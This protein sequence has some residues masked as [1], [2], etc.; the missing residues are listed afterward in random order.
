MDTDSRIEQHNR[1][2]LVKKV[3]KKRNYILTAWLCVVGMSLVNSTVI[4]LCISNALLTKNRAVPTLGETEGTEH[5]WI[6]NKARCNDLITALLGQTPPLWSSHLFIVFDL[7]VQD[8]PV[9]MLGLLP[10]EGHAVPGR[11]VL[12]Y[13]R[14]GGWSCRGGGGQGRE[15][16][17][18]GLFEKQAGFIWEASR[19]YLRGV[20][21]KERGFHRTRSEQSSGPAP[22]A[23]LQPC[24]SCLGVPQP[25]GKWA[26]IFSSAGALVA[27]QQMVLI[28]YYSVS[29]E[30]YSADGNAERYLFVIML[31]HCRHQTQQNSDNILVGNS[32]RVLGCIRNKELL[33]LMSGNNHQHVQPLWHHYLLSS[34]KENCS[35]THF[36]FTTF[37]WKWKW[38]KKKNLN[39][40]IM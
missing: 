29:N 28:C 27:R 26:E 11:P 17:K 31:R 24:S 18:L 20:L 10:G 40:K 36:V 19:V 1:K 32:K 16:S 37:L 33:V 23:E 14:D 30:I 2:I 5:F 34:P 35:H 13:D 25:Q 38:V 6:L 22:A 9:G 3:G 7:V 21:G 4:S 8:D 12:P 39:C 15:R